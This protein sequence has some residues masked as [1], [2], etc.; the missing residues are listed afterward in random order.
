MNRPTMRTLGFRTH[1]LLTLAACGAV[2]AVLGMPWYG[3]APVRPSGLNGPMDDLLESIGRAVGATD[4]T[5]AHDA[6]GGWASTIEALAAV[7]ALMALLCLVNAL[8]G[9]ARE[10]LRLAA[11]ATLALVGWKVVSHPHAELRHGA[12]IAAG[13]ALVLVASA[14]SVA[15]APV[16][17]R[18]APRFGHPG[19]HVPPP[20]PPIYDSTGSAPPPGKY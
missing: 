8:H 13:A 1:V 2:A 10:G 18:A 19:V 4:G 15:A 5:S 7:T 6:L 12:L 16:R 20:P 14:F 11:L 3:G 17:R 9:V